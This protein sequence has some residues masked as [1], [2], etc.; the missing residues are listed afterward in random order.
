ML[1][2]CTILLGNNQSGPNILV[3]INNIHVMRY[4][5]QCTYSCYAL[6]RSSLPPCWNARAIK[7]ISDAEA[8]VFIVAARPL[9]ILS[10]DITTCATT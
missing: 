6:P 1:L 2:A 3:H 4:A 10:M 7:P 8:M 9:H 5:Q